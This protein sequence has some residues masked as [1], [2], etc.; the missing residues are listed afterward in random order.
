MMRCAPWWKVAAVPLLGLLANGVMAGVFDDD[1]A[2]RQ[3]TDLRKQTQT[4]QDTQARAQLDLANQISSLN[5]ELARVRGQLETTTYE[6]ENARKRQQDFYLDLDTRIRNLE[7]RAAPAAAAPEDGASAA[8]AAGDP[9]LEMKS[10][11]SALGLLKTNKFKEAIAGFEAFLKEYPSG[12]LA[13]NAQFWI[14]NAWSAL[15]NCKK[16]IEL[17]QQGIA[18]WP[19]SPKA[20]DA[21]F[22]IA[23]CHKELGQA[24]EARKALEAIVSKYPS[25]P[26]ADAAR[27][28]LRKK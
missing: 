24:V 17:Q 1:E 3:I 6:L 9:A 11:E 5:D 16:S 7:S 15:G 8:S 28:R 4:T 22:S 27:Q 18:K 10:Y 13:P 26:V 12:A 23:S 25:S 21:L 20:P 2:R 19:N 14:G